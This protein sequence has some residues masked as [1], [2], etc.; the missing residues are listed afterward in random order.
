[1]RRERQV[2]MKRES[3]EGRKIKKKTSSINFK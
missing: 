3:E 1:V 2:V